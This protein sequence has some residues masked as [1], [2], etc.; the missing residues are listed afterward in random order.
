MCSHE[1]FPDGTTGAGCRAVPRRLGGR[2]APCEALSTAT[3][4]LALAAALLALAA[5][6]AAPALALHGRIIGFFDTTPARSPIV[7]EFGTFRRAHAQRVWPYS[8]G[9]SVIPSQT[10][11]VA[12]VS[13]PAGRR[14]TLWVAPTERGGLC[15]N[16]EGIG[17]C[18]E[19]ATFRLNGNIG[20]AHLTT[21]FGRILGWS[22]AAGYT[23][24]TQATAVEFRFEDGESATTPI[25]WV[26][27]PLDAGFFLYAIPEEHWRQGHRISEVVPLDDEG[28]EIEL[29]TPFT[30]RNVAW[31]MMRP[32]FPVSRSA[33]VRR[34]WRVEAVGAPDGA[35]VT[36]WAAP[37]KHLGERC[38]WLSSGSRALAEDCEPMNRP[39]AADEIA[40][41]VVRAAETILWAE[42][43]GAVE[44]VVIEYADGERDAVK[45][46]HGFVVYPIRAGRRPMAVAARGADGELLS[47]VRLR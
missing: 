26:S 43:G 3:P 39:P 32:A 30:V 27:E 4:P 24:L 28:D 16:V 12:T 45:P 15:W 9:S 19:R 11:G 38:Y 36:L 34:R 8:I 5:L 29:R 21:A 44:S 42:T 35:S 14:A 41:G 6:V 33:V 23:R 18:D 20:A 17:G 31:T 25:T 7:H 10:R 40:V 2:A 1:R 46:A 13:L 22:I 37:G 47:R